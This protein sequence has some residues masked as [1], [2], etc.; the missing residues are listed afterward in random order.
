MR[1]SKRVRSA[2]KMTFVGVEQATAPKVELADLEDKWF[3]LL[4]ADQNLKPATRA[5]HKSCFTNVIPK[6]GKHA[7]VALT[8]PV[9]RAWIREL[10]EQLAPS[11]VRNNANA[12]R[13]FLADAK[14]ERWA[15]L[16]AN[17]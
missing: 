2:S 10:S 1:N 9:L 4:D 11:T 3:G 6:L 13:R 16:A 8:V 14:A 12:L 5:A 17:R 7:V 15:P